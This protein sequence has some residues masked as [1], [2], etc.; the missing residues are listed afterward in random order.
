[1]THEEILKQFKADKNSKWINVA[2]QVFEGAAPLVTA[3]MMF[4]KNRPTDWL[5]LGIA[6]ANAIL[7]GKK[8]YNEIVNDPEILYRRGEDGKSLFVALPLALRPLALDILNQHESWIANQVEGLNG[9]EDPVRVFLLRGHLFLS[10][11]NSNGGYQSFSEKQS[12]GDVPA[13]LV[14]REKMEESLETLRDECWS[15]FENPNLRVTGSGIKH[16]DEAP[17]ENLLVTPRMREV[18]THMRKFVDQ[19]VMRSYLFEGPPGTGKTTLIQYLIKETGFRTLR[20][21]ISH[22]EGN[23]SRRMV[24]DLQSLVEFTKPDMVI[25]DDIDLLGPSASKQL[26]STIE[27]C[28]TQIKVFVASANNRQ[29]MTPALL[30]AGRFDDFFEINEL[31]PE[32]VK[33][34]LGPDLEDRY[35]DFKTWPIVYLM[36]LRT[37]IKILGKEE[38]LKSVQ[39]THQRIAEIHDRIQREW[40]PAGGG[41]Y[42]E[43]DD[44]D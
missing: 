19:G 41:V 23:F 15:L 9:S 26:L 36:D 10:C 33:T 32:V 1:M 34:L 28:R 30:R 25:I 22:F 40:K 12:I 21:D 4:K 38:A 44:L 17:P 42:A 43:E 7:S 39:H 29:R 5:G 37:K 3:L 16:E 2:S 20:L 31:D 18:L 35:E 8:V 11:P 24:D 13:I 14:L 27:W 6:S